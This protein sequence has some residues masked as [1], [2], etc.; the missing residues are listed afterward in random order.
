VSNNFSPSP[1]GKLVAYNLNL[2][3]SEI[4]SIRVL[5]TAGGPELADTVE[6]VWGE[7][8]AN[9]LRCTVW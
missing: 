7:F 9:L 8:A 4:T 5:P 1:D 6:H 3:G 2:D